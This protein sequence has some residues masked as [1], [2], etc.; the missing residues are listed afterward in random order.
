MKKQRRGYAVSVEVDGFPGWNDRDRPEDMRSLIERL[1]ADA[2]PHYNP[3]VE[4]VGEAPE[5]DNAS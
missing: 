5:A 1:L 2:V 4:F 3:Q